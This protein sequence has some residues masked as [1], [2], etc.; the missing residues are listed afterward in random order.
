MGQLGYTAQA[1]LAM[2]EVSKIKVFCSK[3]I[4]HHVF[5]IGAL[6]LRWALGVWWPKQCVYFVAA[7]Q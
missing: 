5:T 4:S 7:G 6:G 1:G 2:L 3:Y